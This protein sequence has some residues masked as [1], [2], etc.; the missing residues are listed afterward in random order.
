VDSRRRRRKI[1]RARKSRP[2]DMPTQR[3]IVGKSLVFVGCGGVFIGV[4][5]G[6][7]VVNGA[8]E[9]GG[10][11]ICGD[12]ESVVDVV[13]IWEVMGTKVER[14]GVGED[15]EEVV[16]MIV[17]LEIFGIEVVVEVVVEFGRRRLCRVTKPCPQI[18]GER[19]L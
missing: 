7:I 13:G 17:C 1:M 3:E 10:V 6:K 8:V 2:N 9:A 14:L 15:E 11:A 4:G 19:A 16:D 12:V 5:V 18:F